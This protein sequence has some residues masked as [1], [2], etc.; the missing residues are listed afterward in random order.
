MGIRDIK[1]IDY[2]LEEA[3]RSY[4]NI[5][6]DYSVTDLIKPPRIYQLSK[7]YKE[8]ISEIPVGDEQQVSSI[9]GSAIHDWFEKMLYRYMN[10]HGE[11]FF[12]ERRL[13]DRICDR[14][15][16]GKFDCLTK[17][18]DLIDF[19]TTKTWKYIFGDFTDW[20][21]QLNM[22]AYFAHSCGLDI[23]SL[24]IVAWFLDWDKYKM[25]QDP[26]YPRQPI[27][28]IPIELWD[29]KQSGEY[30]TNL[31]E[32]HKRNEDLP[33]KKLTLCTEKDMWC[34]DPKYAVYKVVGGSR[35]KRASR[36]LN[37]KEQAQKWI[38]SQKQGKFEIDF[39]PGERTR[40]ENWCSCNK[41]CSQY[42]EYQDGKK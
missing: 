25:M 15:I 27:V 26:A 39:R 18:G 8:E 4:T 24:S 16:S 12:V 19:K 3:K 23:Q 37:T 30:L 17:E 38:A 36:L 29:F 13:W 14:K 32:L 2:V 28:E 41:W 1:I 22:Y 31:I 21:I 42:K 35:L 33:D 40:C 10:K 6:S 7:R 9:P 20:T 5:G 11:K 34:K